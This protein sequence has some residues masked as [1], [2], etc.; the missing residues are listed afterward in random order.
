MMVEGSI[1]LD[2][3]MYKLDQV[4]PG[5]LVCLTAVHHKKS[6]NWKPRF[7]ENSWTPEVTSLTRLHKL[8][9]CSTIISTS[10]TKTLFSRKPQTPHFSNE[11]I[12]FQHEKSV[13]TTKHQFSPRN[14]S[15]HHETSV[16]T[17]KHRFSQ[18]N[19]SFHENNGFYEN[20]V[21]TKTRS[22]RKL[23]FYENSFYERFSWK[24]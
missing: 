19:I 10:P 17:T 20:S 5:C 1:S 4:W 24:L 14:I 18:R 22:L 13:F 23:G 7:I 3:E 6:L 12:R 11:S 21:L 2:F 16:F 9:L 8:F 15:F